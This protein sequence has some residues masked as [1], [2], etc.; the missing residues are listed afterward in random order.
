MLTFNHVEF[1]YSNQPV[2]SDLN[3]QIDKGDFVFLIG[4]SGVGKTTLMRMVYMDIL[5]E[6]GYVEVAGFN[7]DAIRVKELTTLRRKLGIVF[8]DFQLL[9]D[10]NVYDNLAFVLHATGTPKKMI[11]RKVLHALSDVGL[12]HKQN[13]M[14][15]QL[16]GGEKQRV[17]IARAIINDPDLVLADEPTGNLDL[18]TSDEIIEIL[19]KI[20]QRGTS[21]LLATHNYEIVR[22]VDAKIIRLE[23]G[24][25]VKVMIKKKDDNQS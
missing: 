23:N 14:P 13:N 22:K 5:P 19:K 7:S 12:A 17:A 20:N 15:Q 2:F 16:S 9:D 21:I 25:A 3:L 8:Q 6:A 18:E 24:K 1:K 4:K 10:R 11:K